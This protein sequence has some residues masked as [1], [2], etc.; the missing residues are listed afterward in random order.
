MLG[1]LYHRDKVKRANCKN[2]RGWSR[3]EFV[4]HLRLLYPQLSNVADK[5]YLEM[6]RDIPFVY[7]L[8][9]PAL[10]IKFQADL[11]KI[12]DHYD[13]LTPAEESEAVIILMGKINNLAVFNWQRVFNEMAKGRDVTVPVGTV[14]N[15]RFDLNSCF[16]DGRRAKSRALYYQYAVNGTFKAPFGEAKVSS[17]EKNQINP[18]KH[19]FKASNASAVVGSTCM[20]CGKNSHVNTD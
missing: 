17:K 15:F 7:D 10:E 5:S 13:S 14:D 3:T 2:W 20:F 11:S 6:I 16:E 1:Y 19:A 4:E 8:E 9:N 12:V 18:N